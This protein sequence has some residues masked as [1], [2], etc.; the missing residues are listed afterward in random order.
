MLNVLAIMILV[1]GLITM[2]KTP[3]KMYDCVCKPK[4]SQRAI[5]SSSVPFIIALMMGSHFKR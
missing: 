2:T 3:F 1:A 4:V 5:E